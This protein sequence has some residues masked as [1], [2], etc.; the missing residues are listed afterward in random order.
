MLIRMGRQKLV[1]IFLVQQV[2]QPTVHAVLRLGTHLANLKHVRSIVFEES[3]SPDELKRGRFLLAHKGGISENQFHCRLQA[4]RI[5]KFRVN[6]FVLRFVDRTG[7]SNWHK[8]L[9]QISTQS[10]SFSN[11]LLE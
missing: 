4:W 7:I 9:A 11:T 6:L 5:G 3:R 10:M 8:Y 1:P 2:P